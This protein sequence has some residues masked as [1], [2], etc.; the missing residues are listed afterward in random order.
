MKMTC[1]TATDGNDVR[2]VVLAGHVIASDGSGGREN[3]AA[4]NETHISAE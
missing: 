3:V 2:I 1:T 4:Q